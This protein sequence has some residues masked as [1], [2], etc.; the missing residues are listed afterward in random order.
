MPEAT[1][2]LRS[3]VA[4]SLISMALAA[5][6]AAPAFAY[7]CD[8]FESPA[9][10]R[11][12]CL[13]S[14]FNDA[15]DLDAFS[16]LWQSEHWPFDPVQFRDAN[17]SLAG[18]ATFVPY[19]SQWYQDYVGDLMYRR[20]E[21]DFVATL[22]VATYNRTG[23]LPP[24]ATHGGGANTEYS[25]A[26]LMVRA[27]KPT[28]EA[29]NAN[30]LVG[31]ERYVFLSL[32]SASVTG[33]YQLEA[34]TTRAA[35]A[36]ETHS[37]SDIQL[38]PITSASALLRTA[39]IGP[40]VILLR[41]FPGEGWVVQRRIFRPDFPASLQ[42]G[43]TVYTDW[44]IASTCDYAFHNRNRILQSCEAVPQLADPDLRAEFDFLRYAR[45]QV[46]AA[47]VGADLSNAGA[48]SDAQLLSF[49]GFA[50]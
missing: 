9:D 19:T 40:H 39:R 14:E 15:R 13:S 37:E 48:V 25:L 32:G 23:Q 27:P 31:F 16:R 33:A 6:P 21:G 44:Q 24:G 12:S 11:L 36:G 34:K 26:G 10:T 3:F 17:V 41:Q 30:W 8:D 50:P 46:P 28:V 49:L 4:T 29:N 38:F 5:L 42:V 22:Q 35:L 43:I 7:Y 18:H 20:V 1:R 2:T 45:P 47:L